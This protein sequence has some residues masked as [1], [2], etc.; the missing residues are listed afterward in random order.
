MTTSAETAE[1]ARQTRPKPMPR[2]ENRALTAPFWEAARRHELVCQR[3]TSCANWIFYPREQCPICFSRQLEWAPVSG[4]GRV[5]AMTVVHQPA[6]AAFEPDVPY[7]YAIIQLD[8]GVRMPSNIVDCQPGDVKVDMPVVA[9]FEDVSP[10][11]T[12]V[13]FRPA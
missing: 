10:E 8:E 5:Y 7:V 6:H 9:V 12:L 2:P 1:N 4:R 13:K 11:W 3:C